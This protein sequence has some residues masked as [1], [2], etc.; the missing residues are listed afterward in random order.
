MGVKHMN[1]YMRDNCSTKS[2]KQ[3]SL[4]EL[5]GKKIA[6]D[7]SIYLYKYMGENTLIENIYLMISICRYYNIIPLFIFDGKPPT[8]K[9]ELLMKRREN[10]L[11]AEREYNRLKANMDSLE[12]ESEKA[13]LVSNMDVLKKQFIYIQRE[14]IN[15]V[16]SLIIAYGCSYYDAIGEADE[17]CA[18]LVIKKIVWACL[19][20]D[21][22]LFVYGCHRVLRNFSLL[23]HTAILYNTN[24][25]LSEL[26]MSQKEF[27]EIC[28]LSGTD[29]NIDD[30]E[31]H[32]IFSTIKLFRKYQKVK[33]G[34]DFCSWIT[35]SHPN[36]I[37]DCESLEHV[38]KMFDITRIYEKKE[39]EKM[40]I[41]NG[42]VLRD[43]LRSILE[44]DGFFL[45]I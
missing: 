8:E 17:L 25:I 38:F 28:V 39:I 29:Y 23:N 35:K 2:I 3:I 26:N 5:S 12:D 45:P 37:K 43:D 41:I 27:S 31:D 42:S 9:K 4:S 24:E 7:I 1:R 40:K 13:E 18:L 11:E 22:D 10:K 16:K 14:H 44:E 30:Q 34:T 20:E 19:S 36:Y 15:K 33:P 6:V 32:T 21:M